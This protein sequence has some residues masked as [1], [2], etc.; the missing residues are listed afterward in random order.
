MTSKNKCISSWNATQ[1]N[2]IAFI[3]ASVGDVAEP[4]IRKHLKEKYNKINQGTVN[5]ILHELQEEPACI[6]SGE[7]VKRS[8]SNYWN[9]TKIMHL[10]NIK[11]YCPELHLSEYE[12]SY[13]TILQECS[14]DIFSRNGLKIY[15][16]LLVSTSLFNECIDSGIETLLHRAWNMYLCGD[17]FKNYY[18][19]KQ[20]LSD[21]YSLYSPDNPDFKLS[22]DAFIKQMEEL[23]P[24]IDGISEETFL[25]IFEE[26]FPGLWEEMSIETFLKI[27][28]EVN[29]KMDESSAHSSI[30]QEYFYEKINEKFPE[31][32]K[33][34][35]PN[36]TSSEFER[37]LKL[38]TEKISDETVRERIYKKIVDEMFLGWSKENRSTCRETI[39]RDISIYRKVMEI[40]VLIKKQREIYNISR[41]D[42]ILKHFFDHDLV[43]G[44]ATNE[45]IN[46]IKNIKTNV[47]IIHDYEES[48]DFKNEIRVQLLGDLKPMSE[49]IFKYG[50]PSILTENCNSLDEV[51]LKLVDYLGLRSIL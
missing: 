17:G 36:I 2:I 18:R 39:D 28:A 11:T 24:A 27:K 41:F 3:L 23:Y 26:T 5:R 21:F 30:W 25:R 34:Q 13:I 6:E 32:S 50:K 29:K 40:L 22:E 4:D 15:T 12:K 45:E 8:R 42:L 20:L 35:A 48:R 7:S 19:T 51:Y 49:I 16:H 37:E 46:F 10:R 38:I 33:N 9:V 43:T 14:E 44:S 1:T 31:L 47:E